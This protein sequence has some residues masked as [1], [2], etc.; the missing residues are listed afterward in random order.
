[1]PQVRSI[2]GLCEG[3]M[4]RIIRPGAIWSTEAAPCTMLTG[5]RG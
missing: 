4:P 1:M 2:A 3:P 5:W